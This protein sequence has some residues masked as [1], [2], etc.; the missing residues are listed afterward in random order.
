MS[1]KIGR[2]AS[3]VLNGVVVA[4]I[5]SYA[6]SGYS[7]DTIDTTAFCDSAKDFIPSMV[8][9][10]EVTI[11]GNYDPT[12]TT[13]QIALEAAVEAGTEFG[14]GEVKFYLDGQCTNNGWY[15]TPE[16]GGVIIWTKSKAIAMAATAVGT[17]EFTGKLSG[18]G[19][20]LLHD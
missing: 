14:P 13:G 9:P 17:V 12:D 16:Q 8:D 10:G 4:E 1:V 2:L 11:S 7:V 3:V 5:G 18:G 15:L 6:L 19:L 20:E